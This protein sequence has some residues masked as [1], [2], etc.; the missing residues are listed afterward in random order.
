MCNVAS[1]AG[2]LLCVRTECD[3]RSHVWVHASSAH[4]PKAEADARLEL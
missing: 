4:D 3:G 2:N 1:P